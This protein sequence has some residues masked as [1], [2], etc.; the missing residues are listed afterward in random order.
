MAVSQEDIELLKKRYAEDFQDI[1]EDLMQRLIRQ[2]SGGKNI[3]GP[4]IPGRS[5][6]AW[7]RTQI[8]PSTFPEIN[9]DLGYEG[10]YTWEDFKKTPEMQD[11]FGR[12][13]LSKMA[14]MAGSLEQGTAAYNLGLGNLKSH[15]KRNPNLFNEKGFLND[16][17]FPE[18]TRKYVNS[19]YYGVWPK[20]AGESESTPATFKNTFTPSTQDEKQMARIYNAQRYRNDLNAANAELRASPDFVSANEVSSDKQIDPKLLKEVQDDLNFWSNAGGSSENPLIRPT[21]RKGYEDTLSKYKEMLA[22]PEQYTKNALIDKKNAEDEENLTKQIGDVKEYAKNNATS[23][24]DDYIKSLESKLQTYKNYKNISKPTQDQENLIGLN[25]FNPV[26]GSYVDL[27]GEPVSVP[28]DAFFNAVSDK[29]ERMPSEIT[30]EVSDVNKLADTTQPTPTTPTTPTAIE[31]KPQSNIEKLLSDLALARQ[32]QSSDISNL[33][34]LQAG[35][36][37]AQAIAQGSGAKIGDQSE[38]VNALVKDTERGPANLIEAQQYK[39]ALLANADLEESLD[40]NSSISKSVSLVNKTLAKQ[41]GLTDD[42]VKVFEGQSA[43]NSEKIMSGL[44]KLIAETRSAQDKKD[45]NKYKEEEFKSRQEE[46]INKQIEHFT[47]KTAKEDISLMTDLKQLES[48][49]GFNVKDYD[50]KTGRVIGMKNPPNVPGVSI[51]VLGRTYLPFTKSKDFEAQLQGMFNKILKIRSGSQVTQMELNN[52]KTEFALGRF[53]TEQNML[54]ALKRL[55]RATR[56]EL[57]Y[58]MKSLS[59]KALEEL[60]ARGG[61]PEWTEDDD[62]A[63]RKQMMPYLAQ[64]KSEIQQAEQALSSITTAGGQSNPKYQ[65]VKN[66]IDNKKAVL[67]NL[68]QELQIGQ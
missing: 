4:V 22:N 52:L 42:Q 1:P 21:V 30:T 23:A 60:K 49:M 5:E 19:V 31:Q 27:K 17:D 14:N 68:I 44:I 37:M 47:D 28:E 7:G 51:P 3:E 29:M 41:Y 20:E 65:L 13:Y 48:L 61:Y 38:F 67:N 8:L 56:R 58:K 55:D 57:R 9:R 59:P 10:K 66:E 54:N 50:D 24:Y 33:R 12:A 25:K 32:K 6:R 18:Q 45:A 43:N 26:T 16:Q 63:D 11:L 46:R 62:M 34:M 40:P 2:E 36:I 53:N 15:L 39:K 35:N 64:L